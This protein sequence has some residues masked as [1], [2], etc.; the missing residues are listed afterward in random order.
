MTPREQAFQHLEDIMVEQGEQ[1][2][3]WFDEDL[4]SAMPQHL[5]ILSRR[6]EGKFTE[7][8]LRE[9][10]VVLER[11][12]RDDAAYAAGQSARN[13]ERRLQDLHA[14]QTKQEAL[15]DAAVEAAEDAS[16]AA[17]EL[18]LTLN[19]LGV[20]LRQSGM[21]PWMRRRLVRVLGTLQILWLKKPK[22]V[23]A[24]LNAL[25]QRADDGL[26]R[27]ESA[28]R[29]SERAARQYEL[30]YE[31][32]KEGLAELARRRDLLYRELGEIG[33]AVDDG[34]EVSTEFWNVLMLSTL[35]FV[36]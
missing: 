10:G 28:A 15:R 27:I 9:M 2:Y 13:I 24:A 21:F 31:K 3:K 22:E 5:S 7:N 25:R 35:R 33:A 32:I 17:K 11:S 19:R 4:Y 34:L 18:L 14:A 20:K 1:V 8:Y 16:E 26:D 29:S 36:S 6:V 30:E 23:R 12:V